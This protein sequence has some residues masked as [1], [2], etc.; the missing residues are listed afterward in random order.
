MKKPTHWMVLAFALGLA[1][2]AG[3]ADNLRRNL[4]PG[5]AGDTAQT[6][7]LVP[8]LVSPQR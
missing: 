2:C 7:V 3:G 8:P 4:P 5:D 6:E 1:A